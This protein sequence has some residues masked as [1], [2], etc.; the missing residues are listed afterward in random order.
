MVISL[1]HFLNVGLLRWLKA[2]A[3]IYLN[4]EVTGGLWKE[5][6]MC[7]LTMQ[8]LVFAEGKLYMAAASSLESLLVPD[9]D[10]RKLSWTWQ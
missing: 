1:D 7:T 4:H 2:H 5:L 10:T 6:L 9:Q 8:T 3:I